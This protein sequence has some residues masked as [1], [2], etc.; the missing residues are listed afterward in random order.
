MTYVPP[1][2]VLE[3]LSEFTAET[4]VDAI[5]QESAFVRA[6]VGSMS[7]TLGFLAR[8]VER[9]DEAVLEQ[10]RATLEALRTLEGLDADAVE[11][12]VADQRETIESTDPALGNT[13]PVRRSLREVL[14][15]IR[16]AVEDGRFGDDTPE[17]R[18]VLYDLFETRVDSQLRVLGR[19]S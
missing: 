18:A 7:S 11:A 4:V 8:E 1:S 16:A 9:R 5:G 6:Q 15:A 14:E 2:V 13:E 10:R 3:R 12:F 19:E 17:A